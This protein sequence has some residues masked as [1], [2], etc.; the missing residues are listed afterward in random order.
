[1]RGRR[2]HHLDTTPE[3]LCAQMNI[4]A[5]IVAGGRSSRMGRE[6][7]FEMIRGKTIL[8]R[9]I[10]RLGSQVARIVLNANGGH[11]RFQTFGLETVSDS[12]PVETPLAGL[13]AALHVGHSEGFDKVLTVPSDT[14]FIPCDLAYRLSSSGQT[15]AIAAAGGQQHYLTG[16]WSTELLAL[17]ERELS[18]PQLPSLQIWARLCNAAIVE[19]QAEPYDPFFNVNTPEDLAQAERIAAEFLL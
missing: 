7:A 3:N 4:C 9:V 1:M 8:D 12:K 11:A 6:K 13:H 16:L 18:Q 19:W 17:L 14:P 10:A 5:V 15:A 2:H